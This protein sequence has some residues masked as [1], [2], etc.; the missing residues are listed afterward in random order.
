VLQV[1]GFRDGVGAD[2]D[3]L[4]VS[5]SVYLFDADVISGRQIS[6]VSED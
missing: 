1:L 4:M 6:E 2:R 5:E 3:E